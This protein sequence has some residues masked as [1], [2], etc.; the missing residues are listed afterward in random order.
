VKTSDTNPFSPFKSS[1]P[2]SQSPCSLLSPINIRTGL[3][4]EDNERKKFSSNED[5]DLKKV[6]LIKQRIEMMDEQKKLAELL[7]QQEEM[8]KEKQVI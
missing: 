6:E 8:L 2:R 4:S 3:R 5:N 1:T 7:D